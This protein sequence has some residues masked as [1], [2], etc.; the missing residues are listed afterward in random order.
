M[1]SFRVRF[2]ELY[3]P[4]LSTAFRTAR[5]R[6]GKAQEQPRITAEQNDSN[7]APKVPAPRRPG[8]IGGRPPVGPRVPKQQPRTR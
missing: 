7:P 2:S 6:A 5:V 3:G 8:E 1:T 4:A